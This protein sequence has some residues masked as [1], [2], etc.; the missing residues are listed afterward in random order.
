MKKAIRYIF[1]I[2]YMR[3]LADGTYEKVPGYDVEIFPW[4]STFVA[5]RETGW[6]V[7]EATTGK[8][9]SG[10]KTK[11]AAIEATRTLL[12]SIGEEKTKQAIG[13]LPRVPAE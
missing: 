2:P 8:H 11:A 4:I 6:T 9:I 1:T 12:T 7:F 3:S 13:S 5:K 10:G